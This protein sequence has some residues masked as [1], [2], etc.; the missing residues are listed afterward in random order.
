[1]RPNSYDATRQRLGQG[2]DLSLSEVVAF[3]DELEEVEGV[4]RGIDARADEVLADCSA[5]VAEAVRF[6]VG[7]GGA[8]TEGAE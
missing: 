8:S 2:Y 6:V 1:V 7:R 4:V 5:A 3:I